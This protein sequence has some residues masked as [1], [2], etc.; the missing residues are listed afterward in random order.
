MDI[1]NKTAMY[2]T[3]VPNDIRK[4]LNASHASEVVILAD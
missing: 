4:Q 3:F 2:S 1:D